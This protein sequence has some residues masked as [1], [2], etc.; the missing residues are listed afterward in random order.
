MPEAEPLTT[1]DLTWIRGLN[2]GSAL[3]S[4]KRLP[5]YSQ[6]PKTVRENLIWRQKMARLC[7]RSPEDARKMWMACHRDPLFA[8]STFFWTLETRSKVE[9]EMGRVL[10]NVPVIM[11]DYE[12][13][14]TLLL[15]NDIIGEKD[16]VV[17]KSRDMRATTTILRVFAY[18]CLFHH[19]MNF[20]CASRIDELVDKAG[21][22]DTLF[23]KVDHTLKYLPAGLRP[24]EGINLVRN[25]NHFGF[26]DTDGTLDGMATT[27]DLNAGGR[28]RALF[29][30]EAARIKSL[31]EVMS[32]TSDVAP[33]R[34]VVSTHR[35]SGTG[36]YDLTRSDMPKI[37]LHW[38]LHP[39]KKKGLY[40]SHQ[41]ILLKL[42][43]EYPFPD[44]YP[45]I[46]DGKKR[47]PWHDAEERRRKSRIDM[48]ENVD[49]DPLASGGMF[50][51]GDVLDRHI[52]QYCKPP[53]HQG[54]LEFDPVT[55]K[56]TRFIPDSNGHLRLW[57]ELTTSEVAGGSPPKHGLYVAAQDVAQG[58]GQSN[59]VSSIGD[60][61]IR[62]K[63]AEFADS[64]IMP[65][66]F[67]AMCIVINRWFGGIE[68][69]PEDIWEA[70]GPG[71][72]F[73]KTL[74][75]KGYTRVYHRVTQDARRRAMNAYGWFNTGEVKLALLGEYR[76]ALAGFDLVNPSA[77]AIN[78]CRE[79]VFIDGG[80]VA[81]SKAVDSDDPSGAKES[82]GDRVIADALLWNRMR[83]L[84]RARKAE[85]ARQIPE[86][87]IYSRRKRAER[88]AM[89]GKEW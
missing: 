89:A 22:P 37:T 7:R 23:S 5:F 84:H 38:T 32:S 85:Q 86:H 53:I 64:R 73:G 40:S 31:R 51:E 28:R 13:L 43:K 81:H 57:C 24:I 65:H 29:F 47:S 67:A 52:G 41:G 9:T 30:D 26:L 66:D 79:Y 11:A 35:G 34:I 54:R 72:I 27:G 63:V 49:I 6:V 14:F 60:A 68:G 69:E 78:E 48:A 88:L 8:I 74:V 87:C 45:F 55:L 82:H 56:P 2:P 17:E 62:A 42:D 25:K 71:V 75:E 20:L 10:V 80:G 33:C 36:Y 16:V 83:D 4:L 77:E 76:R 70:N 44:D 15:V 58:I 21:S 50:F 12:E 46:L 59:S 39:E 61:L 18:L 1:M 3:Q 19:G